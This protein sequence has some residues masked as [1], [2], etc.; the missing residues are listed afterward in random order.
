MTTAP[1]FEHFAK[2]NRE[3]THSFS[4][5]Y[6]M[7]GAAKWCLKSP[8]EAVTCWIDGLDCQFADAAGGVSLP[9]LLL[10][11]SV[12]HPDLYSQD[13]AKRLLSLRADDRRIG[14]WPGPIAEFVL[15]RIDQELLRSK[16]NG[17]N[18]SDTKV[19]NWLADFYVAAAGRSRGDE[20][21]FSKAMSD[22]ALI[23]DDDFDPT[24]IHFL[25][26]LWHTEF[27][28]ARHE[29]MN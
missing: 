28:L 10:F 27:F 22:T 3:Y 20:S 16:C 23:S 15:G 21:T 11:G 18:D 2:V 24:K 9:L 17:Y 4:A 29:S 19:R 5:F 13:E 26:K 14:N 12:V 25:A 8:Q 7:A 1:A 6:A